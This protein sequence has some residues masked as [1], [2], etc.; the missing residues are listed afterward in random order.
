MTEKS[1]ENVA[2]FILFCV[3]FLFTRDRIIHPSIW[4]RCHV[5][6]MDLWMYVDI[7]MDIFSNYFWTGMYE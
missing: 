1:H 2:S 7:Y 3:I 6:L 5:L 4:W